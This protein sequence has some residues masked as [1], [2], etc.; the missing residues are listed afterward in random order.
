M[1]RHRCTRCKEDVGEHGIRHKYASGLFC[2]KCLRELRGGV[3]AGFSFGDIWGF[4]SRTWRRIVDF[5]T[6][7]YTHT[8]RIKLENKAR[9]V[10]FNTIK[11]KARD[12]PPDAR[13]LG[14]QKM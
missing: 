4:V 13:T 12:I 2:E 11:A 1:V 8:S 10:A 7:P 9:K 5:I 3:V 6:K 14:P